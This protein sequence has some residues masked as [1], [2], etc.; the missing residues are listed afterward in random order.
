MNGDSFSVDV[1]ED[2]KKAKLKWKMTKYLN[3]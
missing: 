2:L 3:L 1:F